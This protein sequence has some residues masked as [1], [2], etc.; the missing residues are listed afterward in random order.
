MRGELRRNVALDRLQVGRRLGSGQVEEQPFDPMQAVAAAI[1]R[2]D[3]V[4]ERRRVR[5]GGD[6]VDLGAMRV[7]RVKEGGR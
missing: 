2:G 7:H 4:V 6:R 3:R 1:E 5:V